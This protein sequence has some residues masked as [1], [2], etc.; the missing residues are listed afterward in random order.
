MRDPSG[1]R[2]TGPLERFARGFRVELDRR[3]MRACFGGAAD[4]ADGVCEP[5]DGGR[6]G[7]GGG[8]DVRAA[9]GI[10]GVAAGGRLSHF[11]SSRSVAPLLDYLRALGAAPERVLVPPADGPVDVLV[12]RYRAYLLGEQGLAAGTVRY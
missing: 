9:G 5:L 11:T 6:A 4:A 1:V 12:E 2:V 10:C 3:G 8:V 7:R